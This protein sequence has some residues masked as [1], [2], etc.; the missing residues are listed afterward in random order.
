MNRYIVALDQGTTSSRAIV[1]DGRGLPVSAAQRPIRQHYPAPGLVEHD[2]EEIWDSQLAVAREALAKAD[3]SVDQVAAIG[4]TNQRETTVL[5]DRAT[6]RPVANAIV[7]QSRASAPICER[8]KADGLEP[9]FHVK[10]GLLLDPYFSGTKVR[11][12]FETI[13][14]LES[15]A[16]NGEV[17]FG[18][19]DTWLIWRLTG[20]QCHVTDP[21]NASRTL[22]FNIHQRCWDQELL[23]ALGVPEAMLPQVRASSEVYGET[24]EE[25]FGRP[26]PLGAAI[27]DQQS[28]TFGQLCFRPGSAKSTYGTG[29]FVLLNTGQRPV[30]SDAGLLTTVGW[31]LGDTVT[32]CLE[33]SIFIAGA[34]VQW[35]RDSLRLIRESGEVERL[36]A[37][38]PDNADVWFVP[39]LV[40]LGAPHWDPYARGLIIGLTRDSQPGHIARAVLEAIA[41]QT[42]DVIE[43][44]ERE[45]GLRLAQLK[46]DGGAAVN[47]LLMQ[48]QADVLGTEVLRPVMAETTALG[49]AY[50][51]GLALGYWSGLEQLERNW[52]LDRR[53]V[54]QWSARQR[55]Q[56]RQ[57][58]RAAVERAKG[59]ARQG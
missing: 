11:Y 46:V 49:A 25:L 14:G 58:W 44:M 26:V 3:I 53:F 24:C 54:A 30:I 47:D 23:A 9:T 13:D 56:R 20:G 17:L 22:M 39:A 42:A 5:W 59:W 6:G 31:Q 33:G 57:R 28:A 7:W 35:L 37:S 16:R 29:C 34:A 27:G 19:I 12:L 2:A 38:V 40:G 4:I 18:T 1:F 50:L 32:Y 15:R 10:T 43:L 55:C 51:A 8:L 21:S 52:Q 41:F 48:M 45:A 36:A